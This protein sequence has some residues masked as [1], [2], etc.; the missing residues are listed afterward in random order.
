MSRPLRA[1]IV[2]DSP[3]DLELLVQA[4]ERGGYDLEYECVETAD[5]M[6][7]ALAHGAW[8][9]VLSDYTLPTFSAP[10]ALALLRETD[11]D[12]PFIIVSG[13]IGEETA[14][15]ALKA[16]AHDF[17]VKGRLGRLIP[18]IERELRD[19]VQRRERSQL[20]EQLRQAQKMEAIGRL[21]GGIAHDFNNLLTAI[22]GYSQLL[23]DSVHDQP[24]L[25]ADV[26]EIKKAG[27]RAGSL[28]RQLLAFS[29]KQILEPKIL[30]LNE[31]VSDVENML[32]RIIGED[33]RFS[34]HLAASLGRI[35]AD[36]GQI[37]QV[38][39][40]LAV[41]ARDAMPRGGTL[42]IGTANTTL[43]P[44]FVGVQAGPH[45]DAYVSLTVTDSGCGMSPGVRAQIFEPF[46]TTKG[47]GKGTGLGLSTVYGIVAQSSGYVE[48]DTAPD[49][50]TAFTVYLPVVDEAIEC[51]DST[52]LDPAVVTG[53]DTILFVDDE[54]GIRE[55]ARRVLEKHG[56]RVLDARDTASALQASRQHAGPIDLLITDIVMPG[57]NGPEL[58]Q[59]IVASRP[60]VQVLYISGY[61]HLSTGVGSMSAHTALLQKPFTPEQLVRKVRER[62]NLRRVVS[63]RSA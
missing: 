61:S 57:T 17:L 49:R 6:K 3:D 39:I 5:A 10:S 45:A 41:N 36:P 8:D 44:E 62:L 33:V 35:K 28:T 43:P 15:A 50:G 11:H 31:V 21:A 4:L 42:T 37:Q 40:N 52:P 56:Y 46:F 19:V 24:A 27:E 7:A 47:P 53:T 38:L 55:L 54:P 32:R 14:V 30:D 51:I 13:T 12:I 23:L 63:D 58:A 60:G 22:L 20:E 48:V 59:W 26:E 18:A 1:L 29:R 25:R 16:G 34:T 2:E 9:V